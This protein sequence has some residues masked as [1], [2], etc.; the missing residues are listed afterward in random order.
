MSAIARL[1]RHRFLA[2][3]SAV[4]L[5]M[6]LAAI[7]QQLLATAIPTIASELGDLRDS[8]WVSVGYLMAVTVTVP[9][10]GRLG[11]LY[12]RR[13]TLRTALLVFAVG[14]LA[15]AAA[16]NMPLLIA[17]RVLQGLGGGGLMVM[18][19]A[20]IGEVVP[21]RERPRIQGYLSTNFVLASVGGP[22][23]GGYVVSHADWRW[24]FVGNLPL[25]A[26]A[27]WRLRMLEGGQATSGGVPRHD[28]AFDVAGLSWFALATGVSLLWTG[29]GGHR[30][31]WLSWTSAGLLIGSA[32]L[33][34]LLA[35]TE[36]AARAPF[37]PL[38]LLRLR[39]VRASAASVICMAG[40][41]FALVFFLPLYLQLGHGVD[42]SRSGV[43]LLP[44]M[45]GI[46]SGSTLTGQWMSRAQVAGR[47]P[48]YG[49]ALA[50][51]SIGVLALVEPGLLGTALL[52]GLA[53]AGLG[54]V[55]PNAQVV[56]QMSG[57]QTRLG[58]AAATVTLARAIGAA[59][60]TVLFSALFFALLY[61]VSPTATSTGAA[62]LPSAALV[63][64][65]GSYGFGAL[66]L[67][68]AVGTWLAA[69]IE[70]VA[71][72]AGQPGDEAPR[73]LSTD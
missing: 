32:L 40:A 64:H 11:D 7:D 46:V 72:E 45:L 60:G 37:L 4:M 44:L 22:L 51:L 38:E 71:L 70:P 34:T 9:L 39:A 43:L 15:C 33:W 35:R 54:T 16:P 65:A 62:V 27:L 2:L 13:P 66:A 48:R 41:L 55:M 58:A 26:L 17:A 52:C 3:F 8:A 50:T 49:L 19:Q 10:Y 31:A 18:S 20:L 5:P 36:R 67:W 68:L 57:G 28:A 14:S 29:F 73:A 30:F 24:L 59:S 53:G 23:L 42:A 25:V 69:K 12:G 1:D 47:L 56:V 63:R 6:L 61:G 21:P